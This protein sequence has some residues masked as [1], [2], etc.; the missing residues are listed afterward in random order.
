MASSVCASVK[1]DLITCAGGSELEVRKAMM[2]YAVCAGLTSRSAKKT[3]DVEGETQ[4]LPTTASLPSLRL[5]CWREASDT[6]RELVDF[7]EREWWEA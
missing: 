1:R 3:L 5:P 2:K 7:D 4:L 6:L